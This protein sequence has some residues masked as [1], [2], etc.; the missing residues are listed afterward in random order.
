MA[1]T[2]PLTEPLL[3]PRQAATLLSLSVKTIY[4]LAAHAE[5]PC[6]ALR[7]VGRKTTV[8]FCRLELERWLAERRVL[9]AT[10]RDTGRRR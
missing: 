8:R 10:V 9:A 5:I 3:T 1:T 6:Y 4:R 7:N 2:P